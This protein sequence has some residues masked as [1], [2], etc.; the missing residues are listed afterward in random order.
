MI[1]SLRTPTVPFSPVLERATGIL[2]TLWQVAGQLSRRMTSIF[3]RDEKGIRP[4]MGNLEPVQTDPQW[5]D[6]LLFH[7]YFDGDSGADWEPA[8]RPDRTAWSPS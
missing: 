3:L 1:D 5:R 7:E 8:I 2:M 6:L 4:A